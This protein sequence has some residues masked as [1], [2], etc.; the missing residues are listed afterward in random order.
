MK[1]IS[2][3]TSSSTTSTPTTNKPSDEKE[4]NYD[5]DD[6]DD[7]VNNNYNDRNE[8][9]ET[10]NSPVEDNISQPK[11]ETSNPPS[12]IILSSELNEQVH[13]H[14][15]DVKMYHEVCHFVHILDGT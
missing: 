3:P 11:N 2:N 8:T 12:E 5:D 13:L 1:K 10:G 9:V 14:T 6:D 7:D 4:N 15:V